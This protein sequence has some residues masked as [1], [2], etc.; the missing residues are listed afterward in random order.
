[1]RAFS[2]YTL[3]N[4]HMADL[5][6]DY[7]SRLGGWDNAR[8]VNEPAAT[9]YVYCMDEGVGR[10]PALLDYNGNVYILHAGMVAC[11]PGKFT[12]SGGRGIIV[13]RDA[14]HGMFSMSGPLE[15]RGRLRY[16]DGC[17]DSL[18]IA[19]VRRGDPCMNLL[20]FPPGI[21]QTAHTHPSDRIGMVLSGHGTCVYDNDGEDREA[22]LV[23]GIIFCIH[24]GGRHK[25]RTSK[26]SMRVLAYHPD[27]D[28][29][30]TDEDHPMIN[31]TMV[32][33]VSASKLPA[34]HTR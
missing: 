32:D 24:S 29:G 33:G 5:D 19:P 18:L 17:T 14:Y 9:H 16:I 25:F 6:R 21:D 27:S 4:G 23:P 34:L 3:A 22:L 28:F 1:V 2:T 11:V 8:I 15:E 26:G 12:I 20:F 31:R 7:P 10:S 13:S 30:P